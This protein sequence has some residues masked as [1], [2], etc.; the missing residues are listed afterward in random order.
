M[1]MCIHVQR[2][3]P[4]FSWVE[5]FLMLPIPQRIYTAMFVPKEYQEYGLDVPVEAVDGFRLLSDLTP[6]PDANAQCDPQHVRPPSNF[7]I[8]IPFVT[9][10][11]SELLKALEW[12]SQF[13]LTA[14]GADSNAQTVDF[15]LI[16][17][18]DKADLEQMGILEKAQELVK[19]YT[20][21]GTL[22]V[23]YSKLSDEKDRYPAG[24]LHQ[25]LHALQCL[26]I[27]K[28]E[29]FFLMEPDVWPVR[30]GWAEA[31]A[32]LLQSKEEWWL[33]GSLWHTWR[34]AE[35]HL[36]GNMVYRLQNNGLYFFLYQALKGQDIAHGRGGGYD[37]L[38]GRFKNRLKHTFYLYKNL[39]HK[40]AT[41][42]LIVNLSQTECFSVDR[43]RHI[44]PNAYVVQT[45]ARVEGNLV[46]RETALRSGTNPEEGRLTCA[47]GVGTDYQILS[48]DP[49]RDGISQ[50][51]NLA[52]LF[53]GSSALVFLFVATKH[54]RIALNRRR[55][56]SFWRICQV[57][58]K[59]CPNVAI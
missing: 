2:T 49:T 24:C 9:S 18:K 11:G 41:T 20:R 10:Q 36:N 54:R 39:D 4:G 30:A 31:L 57:R 43:V 56:K 58:E 22:H 35:Y 55:Q 47:K 29:A 45:K 14:T 12:M 8:A 23:V 32:S 25:F 28:Y 52:W 40:I 38:I 6:L 1:A 16:F 15:F 17:H 27:A 42:S 3:T 51:S 34:P 5:V 19:A 44:Y 37:G 50:P 48:Y 7:A 46:D 53:L 26:H 59:S 13:P 21:G 33:R